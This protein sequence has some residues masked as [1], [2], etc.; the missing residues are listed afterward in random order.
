MATFE[1]QRRARLDHLKVAKEEVLLIFSS[2]SHHKR[3]F[4]ILGSQAYGSGGERKDTGVPL[5]VGAWAIHIISGVD[6][7]F[8]IQEF[9]FS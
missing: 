4:L 5:M 9:Q 6:L 1:A 8:C 3:S 7:F 2:E